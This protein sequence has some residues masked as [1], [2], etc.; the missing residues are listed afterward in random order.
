MIN[1]LA[2]ALMMST[3]LLYGSISEVIAER[4]GVMVTAIEGIFLMGA[5]AGF[6]GTYLS[7]SLWIGFLAA[8]L[9]GLLTAALYG[10]ICVYL[11]QHQVVTGVAIN[12]LAV[13]M[14]L[15]SIG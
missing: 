15:F 1:L 14:C 2:R 13:G 9:A 5:W 4:T 11:K 10:W 8:I 7:G 6:V 12:I 3:P